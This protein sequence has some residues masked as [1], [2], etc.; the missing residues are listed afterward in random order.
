M[1][2]ENFIRVYENI[3]TPEHC[4]SLIEL[5]KSNSD[6]E[7]SQIQNN[8]I[9][10]DKS[11][12]VADVLGNGSSPI[13]TSFNE[14]LTEALMMYAD[15]FPIL[16]EMAFASYTIKIQRTKPSGGYH[17]WHCEQMGF[18]ASSRILVWTVYLNDIDDGGETEFLYQS[19]RVKPKKGSVCFFP[20]SYTHTHRG[21]PPLK[22][23]KYIATGWYHLKP[24]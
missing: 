8:R 19:T 16:K 9:R 12:A 7:C 4:D 5:Y 23:D 2:N 13:T 18:S 17:E 14:H 24:E 20:A 22:E 11:V 10:K 3:F 6:G 1:I 21:N 15:E